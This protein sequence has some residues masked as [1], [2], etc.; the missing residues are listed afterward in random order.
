M[1]PHDPATVLPVVVLLGA[2][3]AAPAP[4]SE[5]LDPD[6][7]TT[8]TTLRR[9]I[10]LFVQDWHTNDA[11]RFAYLAPFETDRMGERSLFLWVSAQAP[12]PAP[13][14]AAADT[15][16]ANRASAADANGATATGPAT[17]AGPSARQVSAPRILCNG[18]P[19]D[20]QPVSADDGPPQQAG[21]SQQLSLSHPPYDA[22][23]PWS[24]QWYF[25]L[26]PESLKCLAEARDISLEITSADGTS[27][28]FATDRRNLA[29]LDAFTRR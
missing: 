27:K 22:P 6:T 11:D 16:A 2:C 9:P 21:L 5:K 10:E 28:R 15:P 24:S 13:S 29:S 14:V 26:Q 20:L 3:A 7:A 1:K 19:I 25:K 8:V 18:E 12:A 23:V 4:V 17:V